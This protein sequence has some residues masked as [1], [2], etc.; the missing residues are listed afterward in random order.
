[1][2]GVRTA[3]VWTIGA[4]T[5]STAVGQTRLGNY[6]FSGLQTEN[7][8]YVLFGCVA[9][10]ALA[11]FVDQL[12]GLIEAG[13]ARRDRRRIAAG[14]VALLVRLPLRRRRC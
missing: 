3:A 7:W 4:A 6:I 5:L 2:A 1:M 8:V 10:V 13:V 12:L 14:I 9:A 11:M